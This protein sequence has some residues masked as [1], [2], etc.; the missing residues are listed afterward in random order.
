MMLMGNPISPSMTAQKTASF[1]LSF[2]SQCHLYESHGLG[3]LI[4][5][6]A[7]LNLYTY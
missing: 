7:C 3:A 1:S 2:R 6:F 5:S 4:L